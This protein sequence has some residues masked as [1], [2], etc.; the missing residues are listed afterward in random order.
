MLSIIISAI[1]AAVSITAMIYTHFCQRT[2][3][4]MAMMANYL[5]TLR[6]LERIRANGGDEKTIEGLEN[7]LDRMSLY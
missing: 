3:M 2:S 7:E 4:R 5:Y 6:D 1:S